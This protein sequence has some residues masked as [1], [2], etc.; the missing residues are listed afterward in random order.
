MAV[1]GSRACAGRKCPLSRG[2][3]H[4]PNPG[5]LGAAKQSCTLPPWRSWLG[6]QH[7]HQLLETGLQQ[8]SRVLGSSLSHPWATWSSNVAVTAPS[9]I[10]ALPPAAAQVV[11]PGFASHLDFP[12]QQNS[13]LMVLLRNLAEKPLGDCMC[14]QSQAPE[15][16]CARWK[17]VLPYFCFLLKKLAGN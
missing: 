13:I 6:Y 16:K 10:L 1:G 15:T 8:Q 2:A 9:L 11:W 14:S 5:L 3:E 12:E 17:K 4:Q 7:Q